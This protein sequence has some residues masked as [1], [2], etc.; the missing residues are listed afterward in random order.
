MAFSTIQGSGGAP[1]SFVGTSGVD[2]ILIQNVQNP[3]FLNG[4]GSG[5]FI[6]YANFTNLVS[7]Y[8]LKGGQGNDVIGLA[9]VPNISLSLINGNK[10]A[11]TIFV[12]GVSQSSVFGGQ[13]GDTISATG[14]V[15][16][17]IING[18][19]N[20]DAITIA[21]NTSSSSIFG[22]QGNDT[23]V[24]T[25]GFT[26]T[27]LQGDKDGDRI[28]VS[29][30]FLNS[31]INGNEGNDLIAITAT[32]F[33]NST[34]YGGEGGDNI[35]AS[36]TGVATYLSGD[37]GN[38]TLI[39]GTAADVIEGGDG[40]DNMTGGT[41]NDSFLYTSVAQTGTVTTAGGAGN[42]VIT[43]FTSGAGVTVADS[44]KGFG[45]AGNATT[46]TEGTVASLTYATALAEANLA[47]QAPA[48][49]TQYYYAVFA[50]GATFTGVL[51]VDLGT[52]GTAQG[53]I[54]IGNTGSFVTA[55]DAFNG[56]KAQDI[57]A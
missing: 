1:D 18:N 22:G 31:T 53:G 51:F 29:G 32:T 56:F 37:A 12:T 25:G 57:L 27:V 20:A 48:A 19:A 52:T 4:Q 44:I 2:T 46:Y 41:G 16:G 17:S 9:G 7:G 54:Q 26:D 49:T 24:G 38:D 6:N 55:G 13:G 21:G 5:D 10:D 33:S 14:F 8:T 45:V 47:F 28:T 40:I 43:D 36:T 11:D 35:N 50:S 3:V 39:G 30:T 23:L 34:V 42:D 15:S